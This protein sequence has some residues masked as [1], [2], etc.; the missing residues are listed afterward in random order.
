MMWLKSV[1]DIVDADGEYNVFDADLTNTNNLGIYNR[2]VETQVDVETTTINNASVKQGNYTWN[3]LLD[4]DIVWP[5]H[6]AD[7]LIWHK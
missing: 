7:T 1:D 6:D 3:W 5:D 2:Y 4:S